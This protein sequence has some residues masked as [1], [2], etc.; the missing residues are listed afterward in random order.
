[1]RASSYAARALG[2]NA[3]VVQAARWG[4]KGLAV[5]GAA[6]VGL[7]SGAALDCAIPNNY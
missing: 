6:E 7:R 2:G 4:G 5:I 1:M 3:A